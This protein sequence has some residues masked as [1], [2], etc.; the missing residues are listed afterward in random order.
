[1]VLCIRLVIYD[2]RFECIYLSGCFLCSGKLLW[3]SSGGLY[4]PLQ[5]HC[6]DGV[7]GGLL[8][9]Q[10]VA[11]GCLR[12]VAIDAHTRRRCAL[13]DGVDRWLEASCW[14]RSIPF[15]QGHTHCETATAEAVTV[16][17]TPLREIDGSGEGVESRQ[18]RSLGSSKD[19]S[20]DS[21]GRDQT[22]APY[23]ADLTGYQRSHQP[24]DLLLVV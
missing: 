3:M 2:L 8:N 4:N 1:M 24:S 7:C 18:N 9:E 11:S 6:I 17:A 19:R 21:N 22:T 15:K 14:A 12:H 20:N 13:P 10:L 5:N 23:V 16:H